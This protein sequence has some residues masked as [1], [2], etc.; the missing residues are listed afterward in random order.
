MGFAQKQAFKLAVN[1]YDRNPDLNV[2][3]FLSYFGSISQIMLFIWMVSML[4]QYQELM[5]FWSASDSIETELSVRQIASDGVCSANYYKVPLFRAFQEALKTTPLTYEAASEGGLGYMF[6]NL[7]WVVLLLL[8]TVLNYFYYSFTQLFDGGAFA[9]E[10][11]RTSGA[12]QCFDIRKVEKQSG[13]LTFGDTEYWKCS[14]KCLADQQLSRYDSF[15]V[16]LGLKEEPTL[17]SIE[18]M[19]Q[20][21]DGPTGCNALFFSKFV[22]APG[23]ITR[24]SLFV[25]SLGYLLNFVQFFVVILPCALSPTYASFVVERIA[26][27]PKLVQIFVFVVLLSPLI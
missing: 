15:M 3:V 26:S 20:C 18:R 10:Y 6:C 16:S 13:Q 2:D 5:Y 9:Q 7:P 19:R 14:A 24:I 21:M 22:N 1:V 27:F 4:Y 12:H 11:A 23:L 8:R 17:E 25:V